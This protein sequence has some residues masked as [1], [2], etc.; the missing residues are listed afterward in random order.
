MGSVIVGTGI[1]V[2]DRVVTNDDLARIM[3]TDD[4][5]IRKRTGVAER[6]FVEP[7][8]GASDLGAEA[9]TAALS[10]AGIEPGDVDL[11]VTATMTPDALAPG[12]SALVQD[13]MG[14]GEVPAYD[15]RQQC[16]GFLYGLDMADAM[17]TAGRA[18]TAL[19]VGAEVHAGFQPWGDT[20]DIVTGASD[21]EPT[22][23]EY[24]RNTHYRGW[25]VLFGDGAG[26]AVLRRSENP[27]HG[28]LSSKL[29]T[30]GSRFELIH[31]PGVGFSRRPYVDETQL[32]DNLHLPQMDG[33][34]LFRMA[35]ASMPAAVVAAAEQAGIDPGD[36][37][38]VIAHQANARIIDGVR[39]QLGLDEDKVPI[40]IDRYGNTTAG[41]LPI[42]YHE[43]RRAGRVPSGTT[44]CF[45]AFG[46]G[47]HWGAAIYREP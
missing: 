40:N 35:V 2:P 21:R 42:L 23:A 1:G 7:G 19:V 36:I 33:R 12:I 28:F 4:A 9:G 29:Y 32:D 13:K 16:S 17:I 39:K 24:A 46:A 14:I 25:S 5:W 3:D 41:T 26:A 44:V 37:D 20:W 34:G 11:I 22:A 18:E 27:S 45:T 30:D 47:A 10:D 43:M 6:R 31:I 38:L 8:V 15:L